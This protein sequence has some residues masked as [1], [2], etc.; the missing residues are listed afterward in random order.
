M[1][2]KTELESI[3]NKVKEID[4][5]LYTD[6]STKNLLD[7]LT[8]ATEVYVDEN[9]S[10]SEVQEQITKLNDAI[11][12]LVFKENE[13]DENTTDNQ[14]T[15]VLEESNTNSNPYTSDTILAL[16]GILS[17]AVIICISTTIYLRKHKN[18]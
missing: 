18:K 8:K 16:V 11:S 6:E 5:E 12:K 15:T 7:A 4:T 17:L 2:D 13:T 9:A 1:V 10:Y 3:I 14:N